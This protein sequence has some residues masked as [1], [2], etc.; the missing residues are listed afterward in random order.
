MGRS[1]HRAL[2]PF[3]ALIALAVLLV[4]V[5]AIHSEITG[6]EQH[7]MVPTISAVASHGHASPSTSVAAATG[8]SSATGMAAP[9]STS[10]AMTMGDTA[11]AVA[12]A[13]VASPTHGMLSGML[14]CALMAI[15]CV[16]LLTLVAGM[17]LFRLPTLAP[18]LRNTVGRGLAIV[19]S[20][21]APA[22]TPSLTLLSIS[23]V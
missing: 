10:S 21:A 22:L 4:G 19:R 5:F 18:Q 12:A 8:T 16:L 11:I 17:L 7:M 13:A 1:M 20:V 9:A 3:I 6:H 2:S 23:R 15:T 14:D